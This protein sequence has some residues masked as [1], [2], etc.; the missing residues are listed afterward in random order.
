VGGSTTVYNNRWSRPL[1]ADT[2]QLIKQVT[3]T[4]HSGHCL[5]AV[6]SDMAHTL[7]LLVLLA[8]ASMPSIYGKNSVILR[9]ANV[10]LIQDGLLQT[11][12]LR[13]TSKTHLT[14]HFKHTPH[15]PL[16][17]HT[18]HTTSN[19]HLTH[20]FKHTPHTPLQTHT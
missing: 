6:D 2:W 13:T 4:P 17:T 10:R 8:V 1:E 14:Q 12:S 15:T 11:H 18:S 3:D 7:F 20:H 5:L 19:T 9:N 16:Q